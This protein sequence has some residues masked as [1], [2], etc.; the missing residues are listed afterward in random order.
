MRI[1]VTLTHGRHQF[2]FGGLVS[3][4][5]VQRNDC[6]QP[7]R[8]GNFF[9]LPRLSSGT[10]SRFLYDPAPTEMNWRSLFGASVCRGRDSTSRRTLRLAR[11][12]RRI[13][14]GWNE[15]HGRAANYTFTD[16][17]I[18]TEPRMANSVFTINNAKFLPQPRI[19]V[20]W[21]PFR[22]KTVVRAGFRN[23]QRP[24]GRARLSNRSERA[25]QPD[26][27]HR[28]AARI[29]VFRS[30]RLLRCPPDA[31]LVPGGVQPNMETPTLISWSLRVSNN[32]HPTP[33]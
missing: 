6:A 29:A 3:A 2:S 16:G 24:A 23:V 32:F 31:K 12:P 33:R 14:T 20:A 28:G 15:A 27:Q 8:T 1:G 19:G 30:T 4:V 18:S 26:L 7:I 21:S 10:T 9:Q 17:V 13:S 25:F 11:F 5:P 22:R